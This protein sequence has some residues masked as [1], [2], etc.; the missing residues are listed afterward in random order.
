[1]TVKVDQSTSAVATMFLR[2]K[3]SASHEMGSPN[4]T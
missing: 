2:L 1:M 4:V 3:R